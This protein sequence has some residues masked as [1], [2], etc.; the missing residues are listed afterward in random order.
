LIKRLHHLGI[1]VR[2]LQE[3]VALYR[4]LGLEVEGGE[5]VGSEMVRVTFLPVGESCIEL[6][7]PTAPE[8]PVAK[9]IANRGEGL[10]HICLEVDNIRDTMAELA[11]QGFHLVSEHPKRGAHGTQVC[12]VHPKSA[13][14][15][16]IE[17]CQVGE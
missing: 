17:L 4:A 1:A 15:V 14:G 2:S 13:G 12:F 11:A 9:F 16:L 10:H 6:L 7:E 8:S 5:E 3:R